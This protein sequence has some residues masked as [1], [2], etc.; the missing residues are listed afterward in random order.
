MFG[1]P[2]WVWLV[3]VQGLEL[4]QCLAFRSLAMPGTIS[5][6]AALLLCHWALPCLRP[7]GSSTGWLPSS[8][9]L[10]CE[11]PWASPTHPCCTGSLQCLVLE[12]AK[13]YQQTQHFSRNK[14][15]NKIKE[16]NL[17]RRD[18]PQLL[19]QAG[20]SRRILHLLCGLPPLPLPSHVRHGTVG[21]KMRVVI[22][23]SESCRHRKASWLLVW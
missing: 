7:W 21:G 12:C 13:L 6:A 2:Q 18:S 10:P 8:S 11:A 5:R 14:H 22:L 16:V 4:G 19:S 20:Y 3:P 1:L 15:T 9:F 17:L 23:T